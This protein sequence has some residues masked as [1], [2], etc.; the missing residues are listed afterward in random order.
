[1][2]RYFVDTNILI[3][4]LLNDDQVL[5]SK[6]EHY[7]KEARKGNVELIVI[8]QV[9]F[10]VEYVLEKYYTVPKQ[11]RVRY[12]QSLLM[13]VEL[14]VLERELLIETF[15]YYTTSALDI[16]DVLLIAM[17]ARQNSAVLSFDKKLNTAQP[18]K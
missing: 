8:P 10:E 9:I 4:F 11:D 18:V 1:M 13:A 3:R 7:I 16:I 12:I 14:H 15:K 2:K 17:A 5:A 6:A